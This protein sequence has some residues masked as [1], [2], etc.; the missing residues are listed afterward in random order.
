[1]KILGLIPARGGSKGIL[2]K[3]IKNLGGKPLISYVIEDGKKAKSIDKLIV[4]TEDE[5]IVN[6]SRSIGCEVPFIRPAELALDNTPTIEVVRHALAFFEAKD[7]FYDAVCLLQPTSPFKP[8]GFIDASINKF[9]SSKSDCLISVLPI[10]HVFNPHWAFKEDDS[11][12]LKISTGE[13]EIISRRQELPSAYYRDGSVYIINRNNIM[14]ENKI[15]FGKIA[16]ILSDS[17]YY[18]N[19][20]DLDDWKVAVNH[21]GLKGYS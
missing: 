16:Y 14:K 1:M 11:G 10:P 17:K 2:R 12:F 19:L 5:E 3:N 13:K 18:C 6:V 9:I 4:S 7:E 8:P 15:L 21:P 20:D